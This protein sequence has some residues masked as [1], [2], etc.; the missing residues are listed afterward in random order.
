[1]LCYFIFLV[2]QHTRAGVNPK[3][4]EQPKPESKRNEEIQCI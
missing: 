3:T 2:M 1:M 4:A